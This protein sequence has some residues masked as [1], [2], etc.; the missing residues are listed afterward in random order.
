MPRPPWLSLLRGFAP[1]SV[2]VMV[3]A[4]GGTVAAGGVA[5]CALAAWLQIAMPSRRARLGAVAG[6]TF[7]GMI[8]S[9]KEMARRLRYFIA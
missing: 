5:L 2:G 4:A 8:L 9:G 1:A 7:I 6:K 3:L